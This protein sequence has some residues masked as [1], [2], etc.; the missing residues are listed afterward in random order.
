MDGGD[1]TAAAPFRKLFPWPFVAV[2]LAF[3]NESLAPVYVTPKLIYVSK[4]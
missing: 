1:S 4:L 3:R 2:S